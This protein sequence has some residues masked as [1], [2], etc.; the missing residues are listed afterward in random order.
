[1][2][3]SDDTVERH[4]SEVVERKK[5]LTGKQAGA[6]LIVS[7]CAVGAIAMTL[8]GGSHK[9]DKAQPS[10]EIK[11]GKPEA[12]SLPD[13]PAVRK[14]AYS[15]ALPAL[16]AA[17]PPS[18]PASA[19]STPLI[20]DHVQAPQPPKLLIY[21]AQAGS[22]PAAPAGSTAD[23]AGGSQP[24]RESAL[25]E[26]L[27]PTVLQGSMASVLPHPEMTITEGTMMPCVMDVALDSQLP[28]FVTCHLTQD[29][30]GT[31]GTVKLLDRGSKITGEVRAGDSV[32][33]GQNRVAILWRRAETPYHVVINLASPATDALGRS[34]VEGDVN[35]HFWQKFG[36]A[37]LF[38]LI[39]AGSQAASSALQA[40]GGVNMNFGGVGSTSQAALQGSV[41]I[42]P[43]ITV[44]QGATVAVMTARD[45]DFSQVYGL[46]MTSSR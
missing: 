30:Y 42:P 19:P 28:G 1:L 7:V 13:L 6:V 18:L 20:S 36:G 43:T 40:Q 23:L 25:G 45:L 27:K 2:S 16:P 38:S 31:T 22:S 26:A 35:T 29:V 39:D 12:I 14:A 41:N 5:F 11:M 3:G 17:A 32:R 44:P 46:S 4:V 37:L 34:G 24:D 15:S 10:Q 8:T 9:A 33:Q 21:T